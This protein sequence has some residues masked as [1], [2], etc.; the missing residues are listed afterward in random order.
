MNILL[1]NGF[2]LQ[3]H[4]TSFA[5]KQ[6]NIYISD[7][8]ISGIGSCP[9]GFEADQKVNARNRLIIPGLINSHSH[10]YMT[11]LR[12]AAD[13]LAF[14]DWLFKNILPME[15]QLTADDAYWGTM[16]AAMEMIK[17]G[18]TCFLDMHMFQDQTVLA[19]TKIGIRAKVSRGL[20]GNAEEIGLTDTPDNESGTRTVPVNGYYKSSRLQEAFDEM[21]TAKK[22]NGLISFCLAPHAVYTCDTEY[23]KYVSDLA[24]QHHMPLHIH[25]SESKNE[26]DNCIAQHQMT[27][28]Q[29]LDSIGFFQVPVI[30]AHCVHIT[31]E[32]ILIL[33]KHNVS[34]VTNPVSNMKLGNGFAPVKELVQAGVN[35]CIG[36]DGAASNNSL[37][38]F[39]EMTILSMIQKGIHADACT[40]K[41]G[42]T[43]N[44]AT[45]NAAK[46]LGEPLLGR[47]DVG[48]LADLAIIDLN[49][50][51]LN[52]AD[53]LMSALI[54]SMNG[55]E[56]E[57]VIIN[58]QFVLKNHRFVNIDEKEVYE[59]VNQIRTR[60]KSGIRK[61]VNQNA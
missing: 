54:Y 37:N 38:L 1:E 49:T 15:D 48:M 13:D 16:L 36:T 19:A 33:K 60:I 8:I 4:D 59:H 61:G 30:A 45:V 9:A 47:I 12:N 24:Y 39:R 25:I 5:I 50:P 7:N 53:D 14:D 2:I 29:L 58:G 22:P 35:V 26:V 40:M 21:K 51:Q 28:V 6:N 44:M 20:V 10:A 11:L 23:L 56:I 43:F 27:P 31:E 18:T 42:E 34:V 55:S 46:A 32:D 52:P 57:S 17:T 41:A 3:H